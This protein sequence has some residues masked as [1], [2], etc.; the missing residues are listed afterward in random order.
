MSIFFLK[1]VEYKKYQFKK[2]INFY[3]F[4]IKNKSLWFLNLFFYFKPQY[5]F[6]K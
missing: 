5:I 3:K 1:I 2:K 6:L 4:K